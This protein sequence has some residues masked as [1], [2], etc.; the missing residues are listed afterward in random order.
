[1]SGVMPQMKKAREDS[2]AVDRFLIVEVAAT[3]LE[4]A[5]A[6]NAQRTACHT[7]PLTQVRAAIIFPARR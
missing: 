5:D 6:G 3:I 2:F 7:R 1:V 4:L